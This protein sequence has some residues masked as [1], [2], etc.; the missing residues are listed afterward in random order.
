MV[1]VLVN[2]ENERMKAWMKIEGEL[3]DEDLVPI[4]PVQEW[5]G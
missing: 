4:I 3:L 1:E 2:E 5:R